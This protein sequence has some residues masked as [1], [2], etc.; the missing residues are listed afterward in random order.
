MVILSELIATMKAAGHIE[1]AIERAE[2]RATR[3]TAIID[4]MPHS[5]KARSIVENGAV[6]LV[7][8]KEQ[9]AAALD[10]VQEMRTELSEMITTLPDID[11]RA[12]M[13]L[14]YLNGHKPEHIA[15]AL[16]VCVRSVFRYMDKGKEELARMYPDRFRVE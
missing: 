3:T 6:N 12:I 1:Q 2:S 11:Q 9:Q 10:K 14:R 7:I 8:L 13:R 15:A 5:K 4:G 16:G